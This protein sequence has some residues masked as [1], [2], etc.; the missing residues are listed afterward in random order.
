MG[1]PEALHGAVSSL[2]RCTFA[3]ARMLSVSVA[4][5]HFF[6]MS[7]F[8]L[9]ICTTQA[10]LFRP[11]TPAHGIGL[12]FK[13][14]MGDIFPPHLRAQTMVNFL[15]NPQGLCAVFLPLFQGGRILQGLGFYA[16]NAIAAECPPP[17]PSGALAPDPNS[18]PRTPRAAVTSAHLAGLPLMVL[19]IHSIW[20]FPFTFSKLNCSLKRIFGLYFIQ[21]LS[22]ICAR[23]GPTSTVAQ[24]TES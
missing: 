16:E 21:H 14:L 9:G 11:P 5:S 1:V 24:L 8:H 23:T 15:A 17:V 10:A 4:L 13:F 12:G 3:P 6:L 19:S 18:R 22:C 20:K 2:S 7:N